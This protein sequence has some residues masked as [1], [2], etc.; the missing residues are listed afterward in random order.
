MR[1]D[2][3]AWTGFLIRA[4]VPASG[5]VDR[6]RGNGAWKEFESMMSH[7]SLGKKMAACFLALLV[8]T[9]MLGVTAVTVVSQLSAS[10]NR[11]A[12]E[13]TT[14][15]GLI[16][17]LAKASSDMLAAQRGY[18]L[19]T[20]AK[21][22]PNAETAQRLFGTASREYESSVIS[23]RP[24]LQTGEARQL[25][26]KMQSGLVSW[27]S[28][29]AEVQRLAAAGDTDAA[30][31]VTLDRGVPI[32]EAIKAE[33]Q[34]LEELQREILQQDRQNAIELESWGSW[35][36]F[37]MI[38]LSLPLGVAIHFVVH[39]TS[40]ELQQMAAD[41]EGGA[42][43]VASA[44]RQVTGSSESLAR[45]ASEQAAA[46][47]QTS[48]SSE[49][50]SATSQK[51]KENSNAAANLMDQSHEHFVVTDKL[52]EQ[53][54]EAMSQINDSSHKISKINKVIDEIAFQTN[55]LALNAAVEAARAGEAGMGFSVVAE[56]VRNL[57]QRSTQA[58]RETSELIEESISRAREGKAKVDQ[59]ASAI[60]SITRDSEKARA[61]V[62]HVSASSREQSQGIEEIARAVTQMQAVTQ[63]AAA[64]AEEGA[65]A[66]HE[67]DAHAETLWGVVERLK[68]MVGQSRGDCPG[69]RGSDAQSRE[70]AP[71][72]AT[73][74]TSGPD[75][76]ARESTCTTS[77]MSGEPA[78]ETV[79]SF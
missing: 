50:I 14:K 74:G 62:D 11:T 53:T 48:A 69:S 12:N 24:L 21:R 9:L 76:S 79:G 25:I 70:L 60:R 10:L 67:L 38:G 49:E 16:N 54:V 68:S 1:I 65:A 52:L 66:A 22:V 4:G 51:N 77:A 57:A 13:T 5:N 23:L 73:P 19:F 39:R 41:L 78:A 75:F 72:P 15:I 18:V 33:S 55:L 45:G 46:L 56:E 27:Q 2:G 34:R 44:A 37:A 32:H 6:V 29:F 64:A 30:V 35:I 17:S 47:E 26:G 63:T 40:R 8:L 20:Y 28:A 59:V 3:S 36:V 61:L 58:A 71:G 7:L 42:E 31:N 43:Q